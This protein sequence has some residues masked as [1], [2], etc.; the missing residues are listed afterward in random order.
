[1]I[2]QMQLAD[3]Q[4]REAGIITAEVKPHTL[5]P[6][7]NMPMAAGQAADTGFPKLDSPKTV[8]CPRTRARVMV[9]SLYTFQLGSSYLRQEASGRLSCAVERKAKPLRLCQPPRV[10]EGGVDFT[11]EQPCCAPI[12]GEFSVKLPQLPAQVRRPFRVA[13]KLFQHLP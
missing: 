11:A 6:P 8:T 13:T 4:A 2:Y 5:A 9:M 7:S 12:L 10:V 3:G 1:M